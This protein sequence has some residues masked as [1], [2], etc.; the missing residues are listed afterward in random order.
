M[1]IGLDTVHVP[2][3][4]GDPPEGTVALDDLRGG[5]VHTAVV[6]VRESLD[7]ALVEE[8]MVRLAGGH[9]AEVEQ[10]LVPEP[11][12][13]QVQ[14]GVLDAADIQVHTAGFLLIRGAHP[15]L[16]VLW[17]AERVLVRGIHIAE[18]VPGTSRPLR[19][20]VGI[21]SVLLGAIAQIQL[22][23]DPVRRLGQRRVRLGLRVIGIEGHRPVVVHIREHNGQHGLRERMSHVILVVHNGEGL[24]PVP[25]PSE[26]PITQLVLDFLLA[27][28][29]LGEPINGAGFRVLQVEAIDV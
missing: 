4:T 5:D 29:T 9:V 11:G 20:H 7:I 1:L 12:V 19:H 25:L 8:A 6:G 24:T 22:D 18:L 10:H 27:D 15:V 14:H 3:V 21:A 28:A 17:V 13:Q 16:F 26:E 23:I 2:P